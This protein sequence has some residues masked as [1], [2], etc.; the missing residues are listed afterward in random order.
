[1]EV[2]GI[3]AGSPSGSELVLGLQLKSEAFQISLLCLVSLLC[4][5]QLKL[6]RQ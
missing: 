3:S 1:M 4:S 5:S 6:L 2:A